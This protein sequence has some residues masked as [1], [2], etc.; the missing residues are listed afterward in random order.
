MLFFLQFFET[1][2]SVVIMT[3][4]THLKP[5]VKQGQVSNSKTLANEYSFLF[6]SLQTHVYELVCSMKCIQTS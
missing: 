1:T 6:V 2:L 4:Y 5:A 3:T